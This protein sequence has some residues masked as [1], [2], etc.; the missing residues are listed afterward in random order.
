MK[1]LRCVNGADTGDTCLSDA[2]LKAVATINSEVQARVC[3]RRHGHVSEVGAARRRALPGPVELRPAP[4]PSNPLAGTE[5]L[6]Y[7]AGDQTAKFIITRNPK[8]D[9][10]TFDPRAASGANGH[11][12]DDHGR[13]RRQSRQVPCERR[14][15]HHDARDGRRLHHAAQLDR[16][17]QT[18]GGAVRAVGLDSFMRFY[19]IPGPW[20]WLRA[21]Q[22][23]VRQSGALQSGWSRSAPANS[24]RWTETA[25]A[26]RTRPLCEYPK[27]PKFKVPQARRTSA[28]ISAAS[29]RRPTL[30]VGATAWRGPRSAR[31]RCPTG[32]S[33]TP[34]SPWCWEPGG[35]APRS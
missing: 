31:C 35:W 27:W 18:A 4:Q 11:R 7:S 14:E 19:V 28:A 26:G 15:E 32:R 2:Q 5:A 20:P 9:T 12:R 17:L 23:E 1:T 10:M 24:W 30:N 6:L 22:R 25:S 29:R 3:D 8:L 34:P 33:G 13:D 21:V 16:V